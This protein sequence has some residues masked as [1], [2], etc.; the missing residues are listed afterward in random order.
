MSAGAGPLVEAFAAELDRLGVEPGI[1][2]VAVSGGPDSVALL[3][4][5]VSTRDRH[6]MDLVVAHA[7][8]GILPGSGA[9]A[10]R[11]RRLAE[12]YG[13]RF[14]L[15]RLELGADAGETEARERRYA[16]LAAVRARYGARYV[17]TAHHADDQVETV[18]M[19]VLEGSGPAGLAGMAARRRALVRPLLPFRREALARYLHERGL[20][21]WYDPANRDPRHLRSWLRGELLPLLRR[22]L[23]RIDRNLERLGR[24][25]AA[26]RRAWDVVLD[27]L[28]ELDWRPEPDGASV[29]AAVLGGYDCSLARALLM[30]AGRR[31]GCR[32]GPTAAARAVALV[33][34]GVSGSRTDLGGGWILELGFGRA[35]LVEPRRRAPAGAALAGTALAGTAGELGWGRWRLRW[36]A[37]PAPP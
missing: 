19:R 31:V 35:R 23:P 24:L 8:H 2:V 36:R 6:R 12:R 28:G 13:L 7:D 3:D 22:R 4:L 5:L 16:W 26:E 11:V 14:E 15:G 9:V 37:E 29:A 34:G 32:I 17:I 1:A 25:A 27:A 10:E 20:E 21:V 18:L 30:A 33:R